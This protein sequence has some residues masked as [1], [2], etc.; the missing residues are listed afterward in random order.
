[1]SLSARNDLT[2]NVLTPAIPPSIV[3]KLVA[4]TPATATGG[5]FT[6]CNPATVGTTAPGVTPGLLAWGTTLE[7]ASTPGTYGAVEVPFINGHLSASELTG[8]T[9][10]CNFIQSDGTGYGI[11]KSCRLGA[12]GGSKQ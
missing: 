3:I 1:M 6:L 8:L 12:L 4:S 11:C 10:L 5:A 9:S 2:N 7:P